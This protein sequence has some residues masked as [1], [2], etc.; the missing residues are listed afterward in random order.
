MDWSL[1]FKGVRRRGFPDIS[2]NGSDKL[3][4][5]LRWDEKTKSA[6][7]NR[8]TEYAK[9]GP[10]PP[11]PH[12][13]TPCEKSNDSWGHKSLEFYANCQISCVSKKSLSICLQ[14]KDYS[15]CSE[16]GVRFHTPCTLF[17]FD[18]N[19]SAPLSVCINKARVF[20]SCC[21]SSL[22]SKYRP[23]GTRLWD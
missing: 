1:Y 21:S 7:A 2:E 8:I 6:W 14:L 17:Y 22:Q 5:V 19:Q 23:V 15:N 13:P 9:S 3:W 12:A 4:I 20:I 16:H 11:P 18:K 10:L